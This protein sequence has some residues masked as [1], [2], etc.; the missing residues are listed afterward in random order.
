M[1]V[2]GPGAPGLEVSGHGGA[3]S[4]VE[5]DGHVR[6][7]TCDL[8][9][10]TC[11]VQGPSF[12]G[13]QVMQCQSSGGHVMQVG[14]G[15]LEVRQQV[16]H[17]D[18]S[19]EI[20]ISEDVLDELEEEEELLGAEHDHEP[21][22]LSDME[23]K[24]KFPR[25]SEGPPHLRPA[26]LSSLDALAKVVEIERLKKL[27]VLLDPSVLSDVP[28]TEIKDLTTRMAYDWREKNSGD[29]KAIWLRRARYVAREYA[30]LESRADILAPASSCLMNQLLLIHFVTSSNPDRC[31]VGIDVSEAFLTVDQV[32]P[33]RVV[34]KPVDGGPPVYFALGKVLPGQ[35]D[36]SEKWY[37]SLTEFLGSSLNIE[38]LE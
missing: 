4:R 34:Y 2:Q 25:D 38:A 19:P 28:Q 12:L 26:E 18:E 24:L 23:E 9:S 16:G 11:E 33:T 13:A 5:C 14:Q 31:L 35:R 27:G 20:C 30:W 32:V 10:L 6:I 8:P 22:C 1:D 15:A 29:N 36:G 37:V 3:L 21:E 17:E 7:I